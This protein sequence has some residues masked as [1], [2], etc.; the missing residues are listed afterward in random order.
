MKIARRCLAA[1]LAMLLLLCLSAVPILA[2][3]ARAVA[4]HQGIDMKFV[5]LPGSFDKDKRQPAI[6]AKR[7]FNV[8]RPLK[9]ATLRMSALGV[10]EG[11]LNGKKVTDE[12]LRPG[13]T[14]YNYR[15]QYQERDVTHQLAVG[16][17]TL[18]AVVGDGW[19]RGAIGI[20]ST[21][22]VYDDKTAWGFQLIL[23]YTDGKTETI[24]ADR[25]VLVCNDGPLRENDLKVIEKYDARRTP[26]SWQ[27]AEPL[28][29]SGDVVPEQG[30]KVL[31]MKPLTP[32]VLK[33]PN[34]QTVLDFGQNHSGH[35]KFRVT[36]KAGQT[37]KLTMGEVLDENGN[38][39]QKNL[40]AE[41]AEIISGE[42]GQSLEYTLKNGTQTYEP[43]FLISGYRY[44]LVENWPEEVKAENFESIPITSDLKETGTFTC[45][46]PKINKLVENTTW[47]RRSNFVDIPTDCPTRERAGWSGDMNVYGETAMYMTDMSKFLKK[48]FED[49]KLEQGADGSLP[50]VTPDGGYTKYQRSC[51]GWSDAL[52]NLT[53]ELYWFTGDRSVLEDNYD[54]CRRY[55]DYEVNRAKAYSPRADAHGR[56]IIETGFHYGEW[57]EPGR[58]MYRDFIKDFVNVDTEVTTAWFY[59]SMNE[60]AQMARVLG[61][62]G[63]VEKYSGLASKIRDAYQEHFLLQL[64]L[65]SDRQC[66]LVRPVA[67]NLST[68]D[69][70]TALTDELARRVAA[71]DYKIGTGFLTTWKIMEVLSESGHVDTA[72]RLL[73]NEKEPGWLYEVDRGA[74]TTWENWNGI[75]A[76]GKPTDS[77]NHFAPGAVVGWLFKHCA[78]I[79]PLKPGFREVL[80]QPTPGG[81]LTYAKATH[82][83]PQGMIVSEWSMKN[84][85]FILNVTA[86]KGVPTTVKLPD[87]SAHRFADG[88]AHRLVCALPGRQPGAARLSQQD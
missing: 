22:N 76:A 68:P 66:R 29:Y 21:R 54:A 32:K 42:V 55:M 27:R 84:G 20:S 45:S 70:T 12:Y 87:G 1:A 40:V 25:N 72:Y 81:S 17:N 2:L 48:W 73:E 47:S 30:E 65:N 28:H 35:V 71:N 6:Y 18:S 26:H 60:V 49:Y 44:V 19:Y 7:T 41:G 69:Q 80:I 75:D 67:M 63:D 88:G 24:N 36:G 5:T 74:T 85:Q 14:D 83:S 77:Q 52:I 82:E 62:Q 64:A 10:Y 86:P 11:Y 31:G 38:F 8:N 13:Y 56:Y 58:P 43:K 9:K 4:P 59:Y 34:G 3:S 15:V 57:L 78:G 79:Q 46:N 53:W 23:Q 61:K 33:T 39:T 50:Y 16:E 37:V 51:A